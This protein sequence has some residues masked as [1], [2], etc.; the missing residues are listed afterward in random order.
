MSEIISVIIPVYNV[1]QYLY[2]CVESVIK[3]TYSNI[4]IMIIDDGSTD[5]SSLLCDEISRID[6]RIKVIHQNNKGLSGARNTG[7][8]C[9]GGRYIMF[10]DSDD[11]IEPHMI[12]SLYN[13]IIEDC[14]DIAICPYKYVDELGNEICFELSNQCE[15]KNGILT[16]EDMFYKISHRTQGYWF[17]VIACSKLYKKEIFNNYRFPIGRI[18]EDEF[19][20]HHIINSVNRVSVLEEPMYMYFQRENSIT[21]KKV[22]IK[23]LDAVD[24]YL[25]RAAF[26]TSV[27][28]SDL[29]KDALRT[30]YESLSDMLKVCKQN[31][32]NKKLLFKHVKIVSYSLLKYC[33]LRG[34]KLW[35]MYLFT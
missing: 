20:I 21:N 12:A 35:I 3:Q 34:I 19:A 4:E 27:K 33:D 26:Y 5:G 6:P 25:D 11:Y 16:K 28:N 8:E 24:A 9:C 22:S 32:I 1:K 23:R 17:Y 14:S 2:K 30:A 31:V 13:R 10:L 7:I 29:R 18:H 15:F